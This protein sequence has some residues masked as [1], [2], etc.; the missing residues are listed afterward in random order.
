[1]AF[2]YIGCK[3]EVSKKS[4]VHRMSAESFKGRFGLVTKL[5][6][7]MALAVIGGTL[8]ICIHNIHCCICKTNSML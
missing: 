4:A 7:E 8:Y 5:H 6:S 2:T 1:M 3:L